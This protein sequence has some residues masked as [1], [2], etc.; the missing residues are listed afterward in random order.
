MRRFR[1]SACRGLEALE[2]RIALAGDSASGAGSD[3]Y[4]DYLQITEI[5]YNPPDP[6]GGSTFDNDDFEFIE[7]YNSGPSALPLTGVQI[8]QGPSAP[9]SFTGSSVTSLASGQYVLVVANLGAFHERYGTGMDSKIAGTYSGSLNNGGEPIVVL[10]PSGSEIHNFTYG[11]NHPWPVP[12]DGYGFS[13]NLKN[14]AGNPNHDDGA[15]WTS[16]APLLGTPG[17]VNVA[18]QPEIVI[19]E[20]LSHTDPPLVDQIEL[21]NPT[22]STINVQGWF[23]TDDALEVD[24]YALPAGSSIP[25]GGYL[26]LLADNDGDPNTDP[27][28]NFFS[29][30]FLLNSLGEDLYLFAGNGA[31]L[32]GYST[33]VAFGAQDNG[34]AFGRFPNGTGD[35]F[36]MLINTFGTANSNPRVGPLVITEIMYHPTDPGGGVDPELMEFVEIANPTDESVDLTNW[37][38]NGLAYTF[39]DGTM[40]GPG[41]VLVL[42]PF[43]PDADAAAAAAFAGQYG[44]NPALEPGVFLG[45][46]GGTLDNGGETITLLRAGDPPDDDPLAVPLVMEDQVKY[47]DDPPWPMSADGSGDSLERDGLTLFG[48]SATNWTAAAPT[49]GQTS[50]LPMTGDLDLDGDVD[51]DDIVPF[52]QGLNDPAGYEATYGFPAFF[53]GDT[54]GDADLDFDDIVGL[55]EL[56]SPDVAAA[57]GSARTATSSPQVAPRDDGEKTKDF[58]GGDAADDHGLQT[59]AAMEP[60]SPSPQRRR[61]GRKR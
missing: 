20:I 41:K 39:P 59:A 52:I 48:N 27:G 36:P 1:V 16:N 43:D 24:K 56:L 17:A 33:S 60:Q 57:G 42:L 6:A 4:E 7:F 45:P 2:P 37:E 23:L 54:D 21:Y 61:F 51:F 22:G 53:A 26:V 50:L 44:V 8:T 13:L 47:N 35:F 40:I 55:V 19:N 18:A 58:G 30:A 49:P 25:A 10:N 11:D 29:T 32:T 46:Y 3:P 15:N 31:D 12:A 28:P 5:M 9:F 38:I 14:P 34:E